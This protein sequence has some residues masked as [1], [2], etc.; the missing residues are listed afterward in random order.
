M[1]NP[2]DKAFKDEITELLA[3]LE[4]ALLDLEKNP[5]DPELIGRIFRAMHTIKGTSG[6]FGYGEISALTHDIESV[7]DQLRNGNLQ[8]TGH[9]VSLTLSACD[10]IR[11]MV[12][13]HGQEGVDREQ[14]TSIVNSF[15]SILESCSAARISEQEISASEEPIT[16]LTQSDQDVTY[17]IRFQPSRQIFAN[18]TNPVLLLN[19]LLET[20]SGRIIAQT[21]DVPLLDKID[22]EACYLYWDIILT[23]SKGI[24]AIRDVFIFVEDNCELRIDVIDESGLTDS[25]GGPKKLGEILIERGDISSEQLMEVLGSK[26]LIGEMLVE[27]GT[28]SL[29]KV[30]SALAEQEHLKE[31]RQRRAIEQSS[32]IRVPA[33]K[34]DSLVNMVGELVTVQSRLAQIAN[35]HNQSNLLQ[36]AEEVERLVALLRD[37]TMSI[38]MLPIG[39]IFSKFKRLV[40]DLAED[41]KKEIKLVTE[42]G[43]TELDKTVIDRLNDPLVHLIRNSIDH[44]IEPPEVREACGK[45]REGTIT[46]SAK[47]SG[48]S[49]LIQISDDGTGLDV[50]AIRAQAVEKG[51][52]NA[53]TDLPERDLFAFILR[54]GFTTAKSVSS[55]S[56]RGVGMDVV[57][58][59]IDALQGTIEIKSQTGVGTTILLKLPLTLAII[60]GLLVEIG[61]ESFI[62]PLAAIEECIELKRVER[63]RHHG[64]NL[65]TIRG[66]LVPYIPLRDFFQIPGEAP[67]IE[68]VVTTQIDGKR[69]G[70]VVDQIIGQH[71]T[72][73]K[74]LGRMYRN[75][76]EVSGATVLGN[77]RVV[78]ILDLAKLIQKAERATVLNHGSRSIH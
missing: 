67:A 2:Y 59:N 21:D 41:L 39:T 49:V 62:M 17:R 44:G 47:H 10:Q 26:K 35:E 74:N 46:L 1:T 16:D 28:V 57:K 52:I 75:V 77:G 66:E 13:T 69:V 71:Q 61:K 73:I 58:R 9:L 31:V 30:Q 63:N 7:Y 11:Q 19:E 78:L 68:Q 29:N 12:D 40:R 36:V 43:E 18:G 33:E 64:Q 65:A 5:N 53:E 56:G 27:K 76:E 20:G 32:S 3:D 60:D 37:T 42:G 54:P 25:A 70:F 4:G 14:A 8:V 15:Q 72:V 45:P 34:L 55:I 24:N 48:A 38:R 22:P 23:T 6:M 50:N 51:F